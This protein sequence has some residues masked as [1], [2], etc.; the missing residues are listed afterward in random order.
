MEMHR[1]V[2]RREDT[3]IA[4]DVAKGLPSGGVTTVGATATVARAQRDP[5]LVTESVRIGKGVRE[6]AVLGASGAG[7]LYASVAATNTVATNTMSA[8]VKTGIYPSIAQFHWDSPV[9]AMSASA[10]TEHFALLYIQFPRCNLH[11]FYILYCVTCKNVKKCVTFLMLA[12]PR[13]MRKR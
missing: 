12:P 1:G 4:R 13:P 3:T 10:S 5:A 2:E 7:G 9:P 6:G 11:I 8:A